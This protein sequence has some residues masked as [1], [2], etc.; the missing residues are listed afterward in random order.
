MRFPFVRRALFAL[1]AT[2]L[3][4][5][6]FAACGGNSSGN[7]GN[8]AGQTTL[9]LYSSGDVNVQH[10][11]QNTLIPRFEKANPDINIKL[12]FAEHGTIDSTTLARVS[13][14]V[15]A[16]KSPGMDLI[17]AGI[18]Q[19]ASQANLLQPLTTQQVPL[20]SRVD[21]ALLQQVNSDAIPY[22]SSSVVLAYNT[23][24]VQNPPTTLSDLLA[25]IKAHPGKF[26]YNTPSTGGSG[27]AFVQAVLNSH[28]SDPN[29]FVTGYD[30]SMESQWQAGF[31]E[32]R[33]LNSSIYRNG[34]YPNG[35]VAVLQLLGNGSIWMAPVWSDQAMSYLSQNL[36]PPS[37]KL[38][39][40]NPPFNGGPAFIGIPRYAPHTQ[41]AYKLLNW[42]LGSDVQTTIVNAMKGF[43]GI[44]W[45]YMP[46]D[47]QQQYAAIAKTYARG[48]SSKFT[49]DMNKQWQSQ[50]AGG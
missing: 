35:N 7:G 37:V 30:P 27:Q 42:L 12:I 1:L 48:Y 11:W 45:S 22:R 39:Q 4:A 21:P 36:L 20:M 23:Q 44:Q 18:I 50:V 25:W 13:A 26:T 33:S 14:A 15:N 49:A 16:K 2:V 10:L 3:V 31:Q 19:Q 9:T 17:D 24:Y 28:V 34:F 47:I 5:I 41:Q 6:T 46:E 8:G 32:L 40:L 43:P 29:S 38:I